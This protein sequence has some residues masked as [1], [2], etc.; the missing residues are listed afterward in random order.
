MS[1]SGGCGRVPSVRFQP[2]GFAYQRLEPRYSTIEADEV[3]LPDDIVEAA[4][5]AFAGKLGLTR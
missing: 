3:R 5:Q 2:V 1:G 4:K